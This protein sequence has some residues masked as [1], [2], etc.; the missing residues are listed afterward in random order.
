MS[1]AL[2]LLLNG[3]NLRFGDSCGG[4]FNYIKHLPL[5]YF[6]LIFYEV[7]ALFM[8]TIELVYKQ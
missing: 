4:A 5:V 1:N 8:V 2:L 7:K 3:S 6:F